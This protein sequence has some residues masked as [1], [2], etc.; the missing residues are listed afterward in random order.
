MIELKFEKN[1]NSVVAIASE[2]TSNNLK[3]SFSNLDNIDN[4]KS[5][6]KKNN[7]NGKQ[8]FYFIF[9]FF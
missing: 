2:N 4:N 1:M 6:Q 7:L 5:S 8:F 3:T 9:Y